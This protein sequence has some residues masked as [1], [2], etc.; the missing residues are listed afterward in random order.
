MNGLAQEMIL[1]DIV[2][3][4][5]QIYAWVPYLRGQSGE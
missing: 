5:I 4:L 3:I 2:D 1:A